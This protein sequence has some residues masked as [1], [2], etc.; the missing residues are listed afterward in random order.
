[1]LGTGL[2][3]ALL[4][5]DAAD[6]EGIAFANFSMQTEKTLAKICNAKLGVT[7]P[8]AIAADADAEFFAQALTAC[9]DDDNVDGV[10]VTLSPTAANAT[11]RTTQLLANAAKASFKPSLCAG[12]RPL[13]KA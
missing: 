3:F 8:L 12:P 7:N 6:A 10:V 11:P 1:M 2:G 5:A 9:L 13:P 4:T